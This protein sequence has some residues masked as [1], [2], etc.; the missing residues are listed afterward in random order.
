VSASPGSPADDRDESTDERL[1]RNFNE[2]LQELRVLQTGTQILAG[3]LLTLPFQSRFEELTPLETTLFLVA[4][5][6]AVLTTIVFVAPVA[7]HRSL[8]RQ[9]RKDQ[10]VASVHVL[11]RV[12]LAALALTM[13]A[14]LLLVFSVVVGLRAGVVAGAA[15]VALFVALGIVLPEVMRRRSSP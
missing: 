12:G 8:F 11:T 14:V 10:L 9:H 1:D 7:V 6:L 3:F 5:S 15:A 4:V 13:A 2:Q